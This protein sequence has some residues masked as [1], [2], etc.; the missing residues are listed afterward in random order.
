MVRI[1]LR[2]LNIR[3][4]VRVWIDVMVRVKVYGSRDVGFVCTRSPL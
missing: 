3:V 1:R 4:G 2:T